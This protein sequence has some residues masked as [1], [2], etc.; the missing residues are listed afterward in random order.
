MNLNGGGGSGG[1]FKFKRLNW[2]SDE[3]LY[4]DDRKIDIYR[5]GGYAL[6]YKYRAANASSY[7]TPC[8]LGYA[9][10]LCHPCFNGTYSSNI[11][12]TN[13]TRC[14]NIPVKDIRNAFYMNE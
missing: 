7:S 1:R 13:C 14:T 4:E 8:P 2:F 5:G 9:G 3:N 10:T 11:L 12:D 6:N